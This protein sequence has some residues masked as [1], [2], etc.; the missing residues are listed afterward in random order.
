[1]GVGVGVLDEYGE[2]GKVANLATSA[3]RNSV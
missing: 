3:E 1:M 2:L